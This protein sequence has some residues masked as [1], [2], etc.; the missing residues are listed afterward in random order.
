MVGLSY[1]RLVM[2]VALATVLAVFL[3]L[4]FYGGYGGRR[5][6]RGEYIER[7][8][9][10]APN[11]IVVEGVGFSNGDVIDSVY[12][13]MGMNINPGVSWGGVPEGTVSIAII[14][15]DIDAPRDYFVHWMLVDIPPDVHS[16]SPN[17][18]GGVGVEGR[19][20]FGRIG[21]DGPCPPPASRHAYLITVFALDAK[22][23]LKEGFSFEEFID[24]IQGHILGYGQIL[25]Y[26]E[27]GG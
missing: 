7:L 18:S 19:N 21:Y 10:E 12:T 2:F 15:Y 8:L 5:Y 6:L 17:Y 13:C 26:F 9:M 11:N 4:M 20:D 22:L 16:I 23:N 3:Y 1:K 25:F 27:R 14:V 24:S